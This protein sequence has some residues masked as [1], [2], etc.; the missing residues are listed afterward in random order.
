MNAAVTLESSFL[1]LT[2]WGLISFLVL[3]IIFALV[4]VKQVRVMNATLDVGHESIMTLVS[5]IHLSFA[6]FVFFLT[7]FLL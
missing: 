3:Y 7:F 1:L 2:K 4:V 5:Y 6:V